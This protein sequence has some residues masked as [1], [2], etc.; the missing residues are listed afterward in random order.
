MRL[1]SAEAG[2]AGQRRR[3]LHGPHV[4]CNVGIYVI[5]FLENSWLARNLPIVHPVAVQCQDAKH[6]AR[7]AA[8]TDTTPFRE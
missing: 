2:T 4:H 3:T 8:L 1:P 5:D 7:D 6:G